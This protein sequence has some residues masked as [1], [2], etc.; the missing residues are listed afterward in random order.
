MK[1]FW[2]VAVLAAMVSAAGISPCRGDTI[3]LN[4]SFD[5]ASQIG[6]NDSLNTR[7]TGTAAPMGY[8]SAGDGIYVSPNGNNTLWLVGQSDGSGV[9]TA[10]NGVVW[11]GANF[12]QNPGSGGYVS[13][14]ADIFPSVNAP[15]NGSWLGFTIASGNMNS[16]P[17]NGVPQIG[18]V[19]AGS[20]YFFAFD[21]GTFLNAS[22]QLYN[23]NSAVAHHVEFR[24]SDPTD[25][26]PWNGSGQT[27]VAL[28]V[29]SAA[30]PLW[31]Y[32]KTGGGY[33]NNYL[34]LWA[35]AN[36]DQ[37][38]IHQVD[39]LNVTVV[40]APVPE[41]AAAT[42]MATAVFGLMGYAWRRRA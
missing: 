11:G 32:S 30:S 21:S 41:P 37:T 31:S 10:V 13:L 26:N 4:D 1:T 38:L 22:Q 16:G 40:A 7:Q 20:G 6:L 34:T 33:T 25:G 9:P 28:F 17:T 29:D 8:G 18:A 14:S 42:L 12:N 24:F 3:V 39:N 5:S 15:G 27:D 36:P 35:N 23:S 19:F 2:A